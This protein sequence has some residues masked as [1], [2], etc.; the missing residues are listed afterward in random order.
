MRTTRYIVALAALA[1]ATPA[2]AS[3]TPRPTAQ[4]SRIREV[5]YS[6][7]QVYRVVGVTMLENK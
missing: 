2:I 5:I 3:E 4:D 1:L 7:A 6:D